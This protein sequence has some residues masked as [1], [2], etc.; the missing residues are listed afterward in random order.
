MFIVVRE[1][2][3][4]RHLAVAVDACENVKSNDLDESEREV[5]AL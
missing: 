5:H 1:I 3:R 2:E 4:L